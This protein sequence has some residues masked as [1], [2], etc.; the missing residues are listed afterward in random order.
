MT[1]KAAN[2]HTKDRLL[3]TSPSSASV[4][5]PKNTSAFVLGSSSVYATISEGSTRPPSSKTGSEAVR[6]DP[7][8]RSDPGAYRK[9]SPLKWRNSWSSANGHLR[10][11]GRAGSQSEA[12]TPL[13]VNPPDTKGYGKLRDRNTELGRGSKA[14]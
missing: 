8:A 1:M 2:L 5:K 14:R 3:L 9:S 4:P 6:D 11:L 12:A 13:E 7:L 10:G